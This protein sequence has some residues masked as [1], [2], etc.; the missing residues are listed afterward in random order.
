MGVFQRFGPVAR[1]SVDLGKVDL[2][3][4]SDNLLER[5]EARVAGGTIGL[6]K[7]PGKPTELEET[8]KKRLWAQPVVPNQF[9]T[10]ITDPDADL[11]DLRVGKEVDK[12]GGHNA[13]GSPGAVARDLDDQYL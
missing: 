1:P 2:Q 11:D 8:V 4:I 5:D 6:A 10:V 3:V 7:G 12:G 9:K 13:L